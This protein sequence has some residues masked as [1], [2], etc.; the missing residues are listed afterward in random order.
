MSRLTSERAWQLFVLLAACAAVVPLVAHGALQPAD[1]GP[2]LLPGRVVGPDGAPVPGVQVVCRY[3]YE[4]W[5]PKHE[6]ISLQTTTGEDGS[7]LFRPPQPDFYTLYVTHPGFS[8]T[9]VGDE[10]A[11]PARRKPVEIRLIHEA[12]I[13]GTVRSQATGRPLAA[14]EVQASVGKQRRKDGP[15]YL[16][17]KDLSTRTDAN[18]RYEIVALAPDAD[19]AVSAWAE[20]HARVKHGSISSGSEDVDFELSPGVEVSGTIVVEAGDSPVGDL[21]IRAYTADGKEFAATT[22][23]E[24]RFRLTG[25]PPGKYALRTAPSDGA[26]LATLDLS[27][28]GNRSGVALRIPRVP[29]GAIEGRIADIDDRPVP[30]ITLRLWSGSATMF[31]WGGAH[32]DADGRY[33]FRMLPHRRYM[34]RPA[35]SA[36]HCQALGKTTITLD[37]SRTVTCD[38]TAIRGWSVSGRVTERVTGDSVEDAGVRLESRAGEQAYGDF[39]AKLRRYARTD[40]DGIYEFTGVPPGSHNV[41]VQPSTDYPEP[42]DPSE[43][44]VEREDVAGVDFVLER[45][46]AIRGTVQ[47]LDGSPLIKAS[48][49]PYFVPELKRGTWRYT[50]EAG[51]FSLP[52][53]PAAASFVLRVEEQ[54]G[55]RFLSPTFEAAQVKAPLLIRKPRGGT[56]VATFRGPDGKPLAGRQVRFELKQPADPSP[57]AQKLLRRTRLRARSDETGVARSPVLVPG[58][59]SLATSDDTGSASGEVDV[60]PG[61]EVGADFVLTFLPETACQAR[62]SGRVTDGSGKPLQNCRVQAGGRFQGKGRGGSAQTDADGRYEID[63]LRQDA[64]FTVEASARRRGRRGRELKLTTRAPA[65]DVDFVFPAL[66]AVEGTVRRAAEG[67]TTD[68]AKLLLFSVGDDG[69]ERQYCPGTLTPDRATG[70]FTFPDLQA[71][72]YTVLF[73]H[74]DLPRTKSRAFQLSEGQ[75]LR[76]VRIEPQPPVSVTGTV[77]DAASGEPIPGVPVEEVPPEALAEP[78]SYM[79]LYLRR[80][81]SDRRGRFTLTALPRTRVEI[82]ASHLLYEPLTTRVDCAASTI[83]PITIRLRRR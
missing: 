16:F 7:F 49:R 79:D 23:A 74:P 68:A 39:V 54:S 22:D 45:G 80:A 17:Q 55:S 5:R 8:A 31:R 36:Y 52:S 65:V 64:E 3:A 42:P 25:M 10:G 38:F 66:G 35:P 15:S 24:G 73:V 61:E 75:T 29:G 21:R 58:R 33:A 26:D 51:S 81:V 50:D 59:W 1:S 44:R 53:V 11:Y 60:R 12:R 72:R 71:G 28:G 40:G 41:Q 4:P 34:F 63:G 69:H 57:A 82:K 78:S 2:V 47:D 77:V 43:V 67:A 13:A 20:G 19:Y 48:V 70:R 6:R 30:G 62:I 32:T 14:A 46:V 27:D 83:D 18:G 76:D 9:G 37:E 56:I